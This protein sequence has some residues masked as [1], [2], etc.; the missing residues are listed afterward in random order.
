MRKTVSLI[1][2]LVLLVT[3]LFSA[4][5]S[6]DDIDG[7][8]TDGDIGISNTDGQNDIH[9]NYGSTSAKTLEEYQAL[10]Q[11]LQLPEEFDH[12]DNFAYFGEF[13][14]FVICPQISVDDYQYG[15]VDQAQVEL[16]L[17]VNCEDKWPVLEKLSDTD[18]NP[19]DMRS[20]P[21]KQRGEYEINGLTYYYAMGE[22][23][24]IAWSRDGKYYYVAPDSAK[25]YP[26]EASTVFAKLLNIQGKTYPLMCWLLAGNKES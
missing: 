19:V 1:S 5:D 24:A 6:A 23:L 20:L 25:D 4:C 16:M 22:L 15:I 10:I 13:E 2:V 12:F 21:S 18:I 11:K 8:V 3:L 17:H 14:R 7:D 9:I 26:I